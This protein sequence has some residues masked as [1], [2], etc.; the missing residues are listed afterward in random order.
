MSATGRS[1]F[2]MAISRDAE[3]LLECCKK[4]KGPGFTLC[5]KPRVFMMISSQWKK[6]YAAGVFGRIVY[7][8]GEYCH[9]HSL[10]GA[11]VG[12]LTRTGGRMDARCGIR[13]MHRPTMLGVTHKPLLEV[14][15]PGHASFLTKR[16]T[17][18]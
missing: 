12:V 16:S 17:N 2:S 3:R 4:N 11:F 18:S 5:S 13:P 14:F 15:L 8:E 10:G 7:S 6:L 1:R 9:P